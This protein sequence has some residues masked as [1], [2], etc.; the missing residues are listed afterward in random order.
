MPMSKRSQTPGVSH[1]LLYSSTFPLPSHSTPRHFRL[2]PSPQSPKTLTA[3]PFH[4]ADGLDKPTPRAITE[5]LVKIRKDV[6]SNGVNTHFSVSSAK[7]GASTNTPTITPSK[8]A[9]PQKRAPRGSKSGS[10]PSSARKNGNGNKRPRAGKD[11]QS[12]EYDLFHSYVSFCSKP[13]CLHG[14]RWSS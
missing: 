11:Y 9:T 8:A 4:T 14:R 1:P 7:Q 2:F 12:D 6:K 13:L 10:V 5:R 3:P